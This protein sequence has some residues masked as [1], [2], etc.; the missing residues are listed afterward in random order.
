MA[1]TGNR[2]KAIDQCLSL[3]IGA[4]GNSKVLYVG[5][6]IFA[7]G[8]H[9]QTALSSDRLRVPCLFALGVGIPGKA[10]FAA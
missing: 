3:L 4:K 7:I 10:S 6:S 5:S 8:A 1:R 9:W 2:D